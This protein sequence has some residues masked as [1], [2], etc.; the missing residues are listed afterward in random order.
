MLNKGRLARKKKAHQA[1]QTPYLSDPASSLDQFCDNYLIKLR[2]DT[3]DFADLKLISE[4]FN[5]FTGKSADTFLLHMSL[6]SKAVAG[7]DVRSLRNR[8]G[9]ASS[10][11]ILPLS[12]DDMQK[13]KVCDEMINFEK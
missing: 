9:S 13:S 6:T 7:A 4:N 2:Y 8:K 3:K 5:I 1:I 11:R 12:Q 10:K